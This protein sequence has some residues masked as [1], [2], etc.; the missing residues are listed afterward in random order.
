MDIDFWKEKLDTEIDVIRK[1]LASISSTKDDTGLKDVQDK[2]TNTKN[3]SLLSLRSEIRIVSDKKQRS[4]LQNEYMEYEK[5]I[6]NMLEKVN[7]MLMTSDTI[8][9]DTDPI[10]AGDSL[11][12]EAENLQKR[13]QSSLSKT[14]NMINEAKDV[15]MTTVQQLKSQRDQLEN[16]QD[17]VTS[18]EE[19][20]QKSDT[21]MKRFWRGSSKVKKEDEQQYKVS[22]TMTKTGT[23][24]LKVG[25]QFRELQTSVIDR[26][27]NIHAI[28]EEEQQHKSGSISVT[29]GN[30]PKSAAIRH[31]KLRMDLERA[32]DEFEE[33][34]QLYL[35]EMKKKRSRYSTEE[36]GDQKRMLDRLSWQLKKVK[37]TQ[38]ERFGVAV[39]LEAG[40]DSSDSPR[41]QLTDEQSDRLKK[42]YQQ[43]KEFDR[44]LDDIGEGISDLLDI[45]E[46]QNLEVDTQNQRLQTLEADTENMQQHMTHVNAK[47][48]RTLM[49]ITGKRF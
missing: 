43:E 32:F 27:R 47:M 37:D 18:T 31:S 23:T 15:G 26:L 6:Q 49:R 25:S 39:S 11:L 28:L 44:Q 33:M 40:E 38:K 42:I 9:D 1:K 24:Q 34:N 21:L 22:G 35:L 41:A 10:K 13:T 12:S 5:S 14:R 29:A 46:M 48:K 30:N 20:L 7:Q 2:L 45:A 36:L 4:N 17:T 8:Q 16:V 19:K 3:T